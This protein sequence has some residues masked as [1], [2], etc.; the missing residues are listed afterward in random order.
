MLRRLKPS[1]S[2]KNE[3][4]NSLQLK[5]VKIGQTEVP[6]QEEV[7]YLGINM[8]RKLNFG[9]HIAKTRQKA[10]AAKKILN[11]YLRKS[12]PLNR[13]LKDPAV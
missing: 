10:Y 7:K 12:N 13:N 5:I 9:K 11:P 1:P 3:H 2:I 4:S 8:D 6:E